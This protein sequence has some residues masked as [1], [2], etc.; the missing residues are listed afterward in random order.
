MIKKRRAI[1]EAIDSPLPTKI[2]HNKIVSGILKF[3]GINNERKIRLELIT[4]G[5]HAMS[6]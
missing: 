2:L 5:I 4:D 3:I 1:K 6:A